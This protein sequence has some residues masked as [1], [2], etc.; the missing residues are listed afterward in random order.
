MGTFKLRYSDTLVRRAVRLRWWKL[1]G[2][3]LV[4]TLVLGAV[5][6]EIRRREQSGGR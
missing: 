3:S 2:P 5:T 1:T 4:V 6:W